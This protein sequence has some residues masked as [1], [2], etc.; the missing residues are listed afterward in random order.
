M[1]NLAHNES[2]PLGHLFSLLSVK[3]EPV[4]K[5]MSEW[6]VPD[7]SKLLENIELSLNCEVE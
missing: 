2:Y 4:W 7:W 1:G 6:A 5:K 3:A